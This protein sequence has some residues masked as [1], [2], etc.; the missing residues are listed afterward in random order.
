MDLPSLS[1]LRLCRPGEAAA[2]SRA[3][4][5]LL[6]QPGQRTSPSTWA[7]LC[8]CRHGGGAAH[9]LHEMRG[10]G[11]DQPRQLDGAVPCPG[12]EQAFR[13]L[14]RGLHP[15]YYGDQPRVKAVNPFAWDEAH[16]QQLR[17]RAPAPR[18]TVPVPIGPAKVLSE[19]TLAS[20]AAAARA[21]WRRRNGPGGGAP[22]PGSWRGGAS[23]PTRDHPEAPCCGC[24]R[25]D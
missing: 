20:I 6:R 13:R 16:A 5:R 8:C 19:R 22:C 18:R 23:A 12:G 4:P 10:L 9:H 21:S 1:H 7:R 11:G 17:D 24:T 15:S 25:R 2:V 3:L 14:A